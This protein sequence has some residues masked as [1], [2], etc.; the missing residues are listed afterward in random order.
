MDWK[1]KSIE[2]ILEYSESKKWCIEEKHKYLK[3]KI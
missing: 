3:N 2:N 1:T